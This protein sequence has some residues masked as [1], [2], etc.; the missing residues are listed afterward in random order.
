MSFNTD[1]VINGGLTSVMQTHRPAFVSQNYAFIQTAPLIRLVQEYGWKLRS[2]KTPR[3]KKAGREGFQ[4]HYLEF[5]PNNVDT[6]LARDGETPRIVLINSHDRTSALSF[7]FGWFRMACENGLYVGDS[8]LSSFKV[9]HTGKGL[10]EKCREAMSEALRRFPEV[11]S[12]RQRMKQI[13]LTSDQISQLTILTNRAVCGVRNLNSIESPLYNI[14]RQADVGRDLWTVYNV[15]Q[16]QSLSAINGSVVELD[17]NGVIRSRKK[18]AR[19]VKS[20]Q[21]D[22][23]INKAVFDEAY[24]MLLKVGA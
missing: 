21:L 11:E 12:V 9:Y 16:E 8:F 15:L 18:K 22:Q 4:K 5:V 6:L 24:N 13:V 1:T 7:N 2:C 10:E 20:L 3:V 14:Q 19:K 17:A 23:K